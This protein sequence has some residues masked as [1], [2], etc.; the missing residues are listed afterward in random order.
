MRRAGRTSLR[1]QMAYQGS[2]RPE[3]ADGARSVAMLSRQT[4]QGPARATSTPFRASAC[5][6]SEWEIFPV[7]WEKRD[8]AVTRVP[9]AYSENVLASNAT[10][11]SPTVAAIAPRE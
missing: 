4:P 10:I 2:C 8:A 7:D 9:S 5:A 6:A 11:P 3:R 1:V